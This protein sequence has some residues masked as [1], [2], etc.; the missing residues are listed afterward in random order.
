VDLLSYTAEGSGTQTIN[1]ELNSARSSPDD[2]SVF[3]SN[4]AFL[5]EG[6]DWTLQSDN[7]IDVTGQTG[8]VTIAHFIFDDTT[9]NLSFFLQHYLVIFTALVLVAVVAV[10]AVIKRKAKKTNKTH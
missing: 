8:N 3:V 9:R 5:P 7:T 6:Q 10:A 2:W 4:N 1:L